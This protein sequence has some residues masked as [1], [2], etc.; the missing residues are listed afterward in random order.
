MKFK[1]LNQMY[2]IPRL[3]ARFF[4]SRDLRRA[5]I[6]AS[7]EIAFFA[8][9]MHF[10]DLTSE[11]F[12]LSKAEYWMETLQRA[13]ICFATILNPFS[14]RPRGKTARPLFSIEYLLLWSVVNFIFH[15]HWNW[16]IDQ[17]DPNYGI[18]RTLKSKICV[19]IYFEFLLTN[20][21]KVVMGIAM[22]PELCLVAR[23]LNLPTFEFQHG[24]ASVEELEVFGKDSK[25]PDFLFVWNEHYSRG[26]ANESSLINIGYPN[27]FSKHT[28][29]E[30]HLLDDRCLK[31]LVSLSYGDLNSADPTGFLNKALVEPIEKVLLDGC[32]VYLRFHP[33]VFTGLEISREDSKLV[34]T[35]IRWKEKH[36]IL[37][38]VKIDHEARVYDS[39]ANVDI[40]FTFASS[41]VLEAAYCRVP[42]F[43]FCNEDE[44]PNIPYF[45]YEMGIVQHY[46]ENFHLDE[47]F[48]E[49]LFPLLSKLPNEELF[50]QIVTENL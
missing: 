50:L 29:K 13:G 23:F 25:F 20:R 6:S 3:L 12:I 15:R 35:F 49:T 21:V 36:R 42:S 28:K 10:Q 45:L 19:Q 22:T 7:N 9:G 1:L 41:T 40:H 17:C 34:E 33:A 8:N 18:K 31:V 4:A 26:R 38:N 27:D 5:S 11:G 46:Q 16:V 44:A 37:Q 24:A 47:T 32:E 30:N 43:L 39:L 14:V 2:R 48:E